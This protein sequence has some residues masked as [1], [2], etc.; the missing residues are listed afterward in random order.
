M[1]SPLQVA[2]MKIWNDTL[3]PSLIGLVMAIPSLY[4]AAMCGLNKLSIRTLFGVEVGSNCLY[5]LAVVFVI[6][7]NPPVMFLIFVSSILGGLRYVCEKAGEHKVC[8]RLKEHIVLDDFYAKDNSV[9]C[10]SYLIAQALAGVFYYV[11]EPDIYMVWIS[12]ILIGCV[13]FNLISISKYRLLT[14]L[15]LI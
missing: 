2:T 9:S 4:G 3:I 7:F 5:L 15:E 14:K 13:L 8:N 1:L 10:A 11:V 12:C 6:L